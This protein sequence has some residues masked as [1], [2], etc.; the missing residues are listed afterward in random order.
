MM[1]LSSMLLVISSCMLIMSNPLTLGLVIILLC[2]LLC[3][4]TNIIIQ[5]PWLMY[6]MFIIFV[7]ALLILFI[8]M[9]SM[10]PNK[11]FNF[12][13]NLMILM[14]IMFFLSF[15]IFIFNPIFL[16]ML[17][18]YPSSTKIL[19]IKIFNSPFNSIPIFMMN[20]LFIMMI[21]ISKIIKINKG[22]MRSSIS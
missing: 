7:G 9:T 22:P 5:S 4:K 15:S 21:I 17:N 8:Y 14:L 2:T 13:K 1:M 10:V 6:I 16:E 18:L 19:M 3:I 11:K 20:Y 12:N